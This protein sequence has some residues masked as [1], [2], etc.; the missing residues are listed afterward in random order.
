M[1]VIRHYPWATLGSTLLIGVI[2]VA[3]LALFFVMLSASYMAAGDDGLPPY[4]MVFI[5]LGVGGSAVVVGNLAVQAAMARVV[6][7]HVQGDPV[8][9]RDCL[10]ASFGKLLPLLALSFLVTAGM[11]VGFVLLIVPAVM[12][13]VLWSVAAPALAVEN[14]GVIAALRR[15]A[16]LTAGH[17]WRIFGLMVLVVI[18]YAMASSVLDTLMSMIGWA[19]APLLLLASGLVG[20]VAGI[21]GGLFSLCVWTLS[22][23][24]WGALSASLY[25]ELRT[26][27]EGPLANSLA[28]VFA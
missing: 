12:L 15:S 25:L 2:P 21:A 17:R 19:G 24:F 22:I 3:A 16:A 4:L 14:L 13:A 6:I 26:V 23:A 10:A 18:L 11:L 5:I 7:A 28:D 8:S 27:R 9:L 1:A 20:I